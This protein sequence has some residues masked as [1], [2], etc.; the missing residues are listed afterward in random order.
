MRGRRNGLICLTFIL[1]DGSMAGCG[2]LGI[3]FTTQK[4][5]GSL[6]EISRHSTKAREMIAWQEIIFGNT[7]KTLFLRKVTEGH[8]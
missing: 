5:L 3:I 2:F 1:H 6:S 4:V 7:L 8:L